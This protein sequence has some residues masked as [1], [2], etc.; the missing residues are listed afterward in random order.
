M[1]IVVYKKEQVDPYLT[2][3]ERQLFLVIY[4]QSVF[5]YTNKDTNFEIGNTELPIKDNTHRELI[6]LHCQT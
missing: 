2:T 1:Y 3:Q 4:K 5:L 6:K